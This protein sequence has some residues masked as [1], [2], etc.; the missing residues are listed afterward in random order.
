MTESKTTTWAAINLGGKDHLVTSG[1]QLKVNR[2]AA[3]AGESFEVKDI[4]AG[5]PVTLKVVEHILGKKINGLKFKNKVRYT[6][7]YGHRQ[8]LSTVEVVA[9]GA[10]KPAAKTTA[11]TLPQDQISPKP[12]RVA[13]KPAIKKTTTKPKQ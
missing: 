5:T 9:I 1:G 3:K 2:L 13:K 6:R 12:R 10:T 11:A 4:I 7:R 8:Q